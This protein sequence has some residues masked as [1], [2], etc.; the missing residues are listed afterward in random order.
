M[1]LL[2]ISDTVKYNFSTNLLVRSLLQALLVFYRVLFLCLLA[3]RL[4]SLK[5]VFNWEKLYF[6]AIYTSFRL[7][8]QSHVAHAQ[9]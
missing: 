2:Y 3:S 9:I 5:L 8:K 7:T 1:N 4:L 6:V